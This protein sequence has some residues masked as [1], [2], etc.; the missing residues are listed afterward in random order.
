[1]RHAEGVQQLADREP[2]GLERFG[3]IPVR[4]LEIGDAM[5]NADIVVVLAAAGFAGT[6]PEGWFVVVLLA[7]AVAADKPVRTAWLPPAITTI[8]LGAAAATGTLPALAAPSPSSLALLGIAVLA[9]VLTAPVTTIVSRT[10]AGGRAISER[11]LTIAR[12]GAGLVAVGGGLLAVDSGAVALS[13]LVAALAA[14]A[15]ASRSLRRRKAFTG[16]A[17]D[18]VPAYTSTM[19][20]STTGRR[21]SVSRTTRRAS[22]RT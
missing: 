9:T 5:E 15:L 11:R 10:D 17:V 7:V 19:T 4:D 16:T 2:L 21:S 3:G 20:G 8:A 1:M 13:P 14:V 18:R 12:M 6:R 22:T